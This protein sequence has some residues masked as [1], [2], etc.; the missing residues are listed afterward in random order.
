MRMI[1]AAAALALMMTS[2]MAPL[3]AGS[4][5]AGDYPALEL[6]TMH[7]ELYTMLASEEACGLHYD[8]AAIERFMTKS[9][10]PDDDVFAVM[11]SAVA[12]NKRL[13]DG[14]TGSTLTAHCVQ[15]RRY[16]KQYGFVQ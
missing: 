2:G 11:G 15:V 14:M 6:Y 7:L 12:G 3:F 9:F 4:A 16:A 8:Q 5:Y 10:K 1:G 13:V